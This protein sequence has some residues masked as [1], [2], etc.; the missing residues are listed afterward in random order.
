M[1]NPDLFKKWVT[2]IEEHQKFDN[3]KVNY[4]IC[5]KHFQST[6]FEILGKKQFL[7]KEAVPTIFGEI[8]DSQDFHSDCNECTECSECPNHKAK[9]TELEREIHRLKIKHDVEVQKLSK[10][11]ESLQILNRNQKQDIAIIEKKLLQEQSQNLKLVAKVKELNEEN[12]KK[13]FNGDEAEFNKVK[14]FDRSLFCYEFMRS[15]LIP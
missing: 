2:A 12:C 8:N 11:I 1:Y 15:C 7:K 4:N 3:N 10:K 9:L 5:L 6:D 13:H 14:F